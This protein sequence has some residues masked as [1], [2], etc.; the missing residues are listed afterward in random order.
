MDYYLAVPAGEGSFLTEAV[1]SLLAWVARQEDGEFLVSLILGGIFAFLFAFCQFAAAP[2]WG[3][4][5]DRFG[6]KP[7]LTLTIS[8]T[9]IAQLF[10]V[11]GGMLEMFVLARILGG[12]MAG[13]VSVASAA[14]VDSTPPKGRARAMTTVGLAY[15]LG[16]IAG[17]FLGGLLGPVNI[18]EAFPALE[19]WG[20]HPYSVAALA[21]CF[22]CAINLVCL[23]R[24]FPETLTNERRNA[25]LRLGPRLVLELLHRPGAAALRRI[26]TANTV[27]FLVFVG[28]EFNLAFY[29]YEYLGFGIGET[30]VIYILMGVAQIVSQFG[31]LPLIVP[32][33]GE[34]RICVLGLSVLAVGIFITI[35][36]MSAAA[37]YSGAVVMSLGGSL[38]FPSAS[39]LVSYH[40]PY[41]EQGRMLGLYRSRGDFGQAVGPLTMAACFFL[42]GAHAAF[43]LFAVALI[44]PI[45]LL[46]R[47]PER[48]AEGV[49]APLAEADEDPD[50]SAVAEARTP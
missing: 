36:H 16:F 32:L 15:G 42:L 3:R 24:L 45:V 27:F 34:R 48:P 7:I 47:V 5:S 1:R 38:V 44:V 12:C 6:R 43:V 49:S 25:Q 4:V 30:S 18:L 10:W 11:F 46:A 26:N 9:V 28:V 8:G 40:A 41:N 35:S 21:A 2:L 37:F 13:N 33:L 14:I 29:G 31:I 19:A 22:L 50:A 39:A 20:M 23:R 17:P